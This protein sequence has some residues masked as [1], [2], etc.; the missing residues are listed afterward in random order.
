MN[1]TLYVAAGGG[2]DALAAALLHHAHGGVGGVPT[3]ATLSWDRLI[4]DPLPGPRSV[5]DFVALGTLNTLINVV[6]PS[7]R[8]VPP[9]GSTLP[10]LAAALVGPLAANLVLLDPQN[11]VPGLR[12]QLLN[13]IR[14]IGA[15]HVTLVDV[16]GDILALGSEP[17]LRSPLGDALIL[18]ASHSLPVPTTI[19]VAGP[20]VDGELSEL[21]VRANLRDLGAELVSL[22]RGDLF[23]FALPILRWHPSEATALLVAASRGIT[24]RVDIRAGGMTVDLNQGSGD[25]FDIQHERLFANAPLARAVLNAPSLTAADVSVAAICHRSEIGFETMKAAHMDPHRPPVDDTTVVQTVRGYL[26]SCHHERVTHATYRRLAE[27]TTVRDVRALRQL[28][29]SYW[30]AADEPPLWRLPRPSTLTAPG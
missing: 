26:R 18:A 19:W 13:Q 29:L 14:A 11:G 21:Q 10:A 27:L 23:D 7:T 25:V 22:P 16:G 4:V 12:Q 24:G 20:G 9:A 30:P 2:G 8:P 28:L 3:I 6:V 17:G 1:T 5:G 15:D